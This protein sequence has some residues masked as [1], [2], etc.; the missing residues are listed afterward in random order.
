MAGFVSFGLLLLLMSWFFLRR[1]QMW[2]L[3][4]KHG[5]T[6]MADASYLQLCDC[7][8]QDCPLADG[9]NVN[10]S[11][12]ILSVDNFKKFAEENW[13]REGNYLHRRFILLD[14]EYGLLESDAYF[15]IVD[16]RIILGQDVIDDIIENSDADPVYV[17]NYAIQVLQ[18]MRS[19]DGFDAD[20]A[21]VNDAYRR[22]KRSADLSVSR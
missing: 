14:P 19:R 1:L 17:V 13:L 9:E 12:A 2:N 20:D 8:S 18:C 5:G 11:C 4:E 21:R 7:G 6:A 15:T 3:E 22:L 10:G 16:G